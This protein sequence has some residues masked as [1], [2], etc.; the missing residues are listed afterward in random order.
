MKE[1]ILSVLGAILARSVFPALFIEQHKWFLLTFPTEM[2][3][4]YLYRV[5][6]TIVIHQS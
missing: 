1:K 4:I 3:N 2:D 6:I 5:E